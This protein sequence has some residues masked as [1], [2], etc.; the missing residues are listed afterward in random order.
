[1]PI[2]PLL[3]EKLY[4]LAKEVVER[5]QKKIS[6]LYPPASKPGEY[7]RRRT[8][9][10]MR[11]TQVYP[12]TVRGVEFAGQVR[13]GYLQRAWYGVRLEFDMG[14]LSLADTLREVLGGRSLP[15]GVTYRRDRSTL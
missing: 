13:M 1:M 14:R 3:A 8:G 6:T 12:R 2:D 10:L 4:R 7:P 9:N 11:S 5:H 15:P